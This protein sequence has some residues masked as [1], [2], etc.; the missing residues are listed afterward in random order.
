MLIPVFLDINDGTG[1][2][3]ASILAVVYI[4]QRHAFQTNFRCSFPNYTDIIY[5]HCVKDE[6]KLCFKH[7][8]SSRFFGY[9]NLT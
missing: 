8:Q 2:A 6:L 3:W 7:L 9:I 4:D 1:G 5:E